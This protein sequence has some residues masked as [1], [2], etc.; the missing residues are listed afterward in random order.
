MVK[1]IDALARGLAVLEALAD[2]PTRSLAE[3]QRDTGLAKATLMRILK[4]LVEQG[5][6]YRTLGD[7]RYRLCAGLRIR[8]RQPDRYDWLVEQAGPVL[9]R[10]QEKVG[11]PSDISVPD[12]ER[13]RIIETNRRALGLSLNYQVVGFRPHYLWSAMGRAYLAF[14][15]EQERE[16]ILA[17]LRASSDPRDRVAASPAAVEQVLQ[18]SRARGFS[19]RAPNYWP[20][21]H[22]PVVPF[23]AIAVPIMVGGR[24]VAAMSIVW[25]SQAMEREFAVSEHLP[26]LQEA[27]AELQAVGLAQQVQAR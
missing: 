4:T 23:D 9:E 24:A 11:W 5:W 20:N 1:S 7:N 17:A 13:M 18:E 10:L 21:P 8:S 16:E 26:R 3:L 22:S 6:V 15:A 2:S 12:G 25:V 19:T 14:C 27:A